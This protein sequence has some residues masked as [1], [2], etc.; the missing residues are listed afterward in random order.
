ME[1]R[2][3]TTADTSALA[4]LG[5][6]SFCA[7][8]AHLYE[9][10]NL[11]AFLQSAYDPAIVESEIADPT[12]QHRLAFDDGRLIGFAK[13]KLVSPYDQYSDAHRPLFLSQLYTAPDLTGRGIG[14]MLMDWIFATAKTVQADAIQLSVWSENFAA[15]KFYQRYDFGKIANID[16]MVGNHRDDE[17]LLE[18]KL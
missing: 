4:A 11:N 5:R 13:I 2:S 14:A 18:V 8:F 17:F 12:F 15:Q 1:H 7:A 6:E 10:S 3:A 16:F 9:P